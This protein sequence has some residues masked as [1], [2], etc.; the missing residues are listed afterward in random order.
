M[1]ERFTFAGLHDLFSETQNLE[2]YMRLFYFLGDLHE[3]AR[4]R[5]F[6]T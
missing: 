3:G 4:R 6:I 2:V 1:Q 5:S